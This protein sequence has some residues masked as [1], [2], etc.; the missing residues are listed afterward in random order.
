MQKFS[1]IAAVLF[2]HIIIKIER[3]RAEVEKC[4]QK[5]LWLVQNA[6]TVIIT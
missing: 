5:L 4:V 6:K 2:A 1:K 3:W